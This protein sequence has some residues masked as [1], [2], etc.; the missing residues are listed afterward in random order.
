[1]D[2]SGSAGRNEARTAMSGSEEPTATSTLTSRDVR[3]PYLSGSY[4]PIQDRDHRRPRRRGRG[5]ARRPRR[6]LPAQQQ[7]PP[8]RA[9]GP[10]PLVRRRRHGPRRPDSAT[11]RPPTATA[12]CARPGLAEDE[13][14]GRVP[15]HRHPRAARPDPARRALEGHGQHRPGL[16]RRP[17]PGRVVAGRASPTCSACPTW[18]PWGSRPTGASVTSGLSAHPKVDPVTGEM[19]WFDYQPLPPY[20]TYG[21]ISAD[22]ELVH[23]AE[24]TLD[25]PRLQHDI[26]ITEQLHGA[27]GHVDDVGP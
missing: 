24:I 13:A 6:L 23:Q 26:A 9:R 19:I 14:A 5:P 22:G 25:G 27:H 4:E 11:A 18:R 21:V 3:S 10:L 20:L 1:M 15:D 17:A 2:A 8:L 12:T 16:P 7:Q